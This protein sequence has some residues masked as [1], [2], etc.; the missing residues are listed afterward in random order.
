MIQQM[1]QSMQT[2]QPVIDQT[3][4]DEA[5]AADTMRSLVDYLARHRNGWR[6]YSGR[7]I[8]DDAK[9]LKAFNDG[10]I[11]I[12]SAGRQSQALRDQYFQIVNQSIDNA[13]SAAGLKWAGRADR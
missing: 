7:I 4:D 11:K 6:V 10:V 13:A 2:V 5:L 1:D 9:D 8:F 3:W 12:Q